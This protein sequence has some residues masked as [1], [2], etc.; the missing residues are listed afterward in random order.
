MSKN[1]NT[2]NKACNSRFIELE[3]G[4]WFTRKTQSKCSDLLREEDM[5]VTSYHEQYIMIKKETAIKKLR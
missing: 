3:C 4:C 2:K 1:L 5:C